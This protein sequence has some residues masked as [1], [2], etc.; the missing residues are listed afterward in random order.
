MKN[1]DEILLVF[2]EVYRQMIFISSCLGQFFF[3]IMSRKFIGL[4]ETG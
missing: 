2:F 4:Y 1:L 3:L